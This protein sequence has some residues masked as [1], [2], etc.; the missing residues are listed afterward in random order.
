MLRDSADAP[1][2]EP[3]AAFEAADDGRWEDGPDD[4]EGDPGT[5]DDEAPRAAP[6]VDTAPGRA[7]MEALLKAARTQPAADVIVLISELLSDEVALTELADAMRGDRPRMETDFMQLRAVERLHHRAGKVEKRVRE[8][9]AERT[10]AA[11]AAAREARDTEGG[12]GLAGRLRRVL[13]N[14]RLPVGLRDPPGWRCEPDG[15][16]RI[17]TN[18]ETGEEI[19]TRVAH[20]PLVIEG[21]YVDIDTRAVS[22]ALGWPSVGGG[23]GVHPVPRQKTAD[24]RSLVEIAGIDGPIVSTNASAAVAYLA[25]AEA[26]NAEAAP[27]VRVAG[28]GGF[29]GAG[30]ERSFLWGPHLITAGEVRMAPPIEDRAPADWGDDGVHLLTSD[31]GSIALA[32]GFG[33]G[34]T[35]DGWLA[36]FRLALPYPAVVLGV[37]AALVPPLMSVLSSVH[38]VAFEWSGETSKGKTTAMR[39][40]AS[41]WGYPD[42]EDGGLIRTW[43]STPVFIE[44]LTTFCNHLPLF[45]DDTRRARRPEDIATT[46]YN[47]ASGQS[48]G[49]GSVTGLRAFHTSKGVLFL[50]SESPASSMSNRGAR[51][52]GCSRFGAPPSAP[53]TTPPPPW[54][55]SFAPACSKKAAGDPVAGRLA[56]AV[57]AIEVAKVLAERALGL[58][59][60]TIDPMPTLWKAV[61][62]GARDADRPA[63][64][65][66]DVLAWCAG[67]AHR[68][69]PGFPR[70]D[71]DAHPTLGWIGARIDRVT[72]GAVA[73]LPTELRGFLEKQ[74]FDV[75]ATLRAWDERGWT[76]RDG[77]HRTVKTIVDRDRP[78]C[79]VITAVAEEDAEKRLI[80]SVEDASGDEGA[81]S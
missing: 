19:E 25:D 60:P 12:P 2:F 20:R 76:R 34:G 42:E 50:T 41:V 9:A 44:G 78:R 74:G 6:K 21:R 63:A 38:N 77:N 66:V 54:W 14:H 73:L 27:Q 64:A 48:R 22:L 23:W 30:D 26:A 16:I 3:D 8:L 68:L 67:Q 17:E 28:R 4:P 65:L 35:W 18:R 40:A 39:L 51:G 11:C 45:V 32:R 69:Y 5:S 33:A 7:R 13:G 31:P 24:A 71:G 46:L 81:G 43:D 47:F 58:P 57:A 55:P 29:H 72:D 10:A 49:R 75:E 37:Y 36:A 70:D 52:P 80:G 15:L 59:A 62:A 53:R 79:V 61:Q 56:Y 1:P